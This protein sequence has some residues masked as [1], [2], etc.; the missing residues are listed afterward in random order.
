VIA[1][2]NEPVAKLVAIG[3][4]CK[5]RVPGRLAGKITYRRWDFVLVVQRGSV[6]SVTGGASSRYGYSDC[7]RWS[8]AR[9]LW[10]QATVV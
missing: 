5:K 1:K 4:S 9:S 6:W 10:H 7:K 2:G 3:P 8:I